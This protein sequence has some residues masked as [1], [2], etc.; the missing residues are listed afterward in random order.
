MLIWTS[1]LHSWVFASTLHQIHRFLSL[2][3]HTHTN[4]HL[5]MI[6]WE[7]LL[8]A[9]KQMLKEALG[10]RRKMQRS[11]H[12]YLAME[13]ATGLWFPR[14][15]V[16]Y[17]KELLRVNMNCVYIYCVCMSFKGLNRCGKSCRLR[18]T[19]YLRPDL[20]HDNFTPEE[21]ECILELHKIMGS[22][23]VLFF[24]KNYINLLP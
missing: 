19:N 18:W 23:Q 3:L 24:S 2:L 5:S 13:L 12:T 22:R 7:D 21:E 4:K 8:A 10:Q 9:I 6:W 14:K 11:L 15:Q 20:K 16:I 17:Q 1:T